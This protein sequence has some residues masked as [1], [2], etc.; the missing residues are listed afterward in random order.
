[1]YAISMLCIPRPEEIEHYSVDLI[2]KFL[3][4]TS[5]T[6]GGREEL[7]P[8]LKYLRVVAFFISNAMTILKGLSFEQQD[9]F[10]LFFKR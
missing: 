6:L 1:M 10:S 5:V 9:S 7:S 2:E 4:H 3:E 8:Q